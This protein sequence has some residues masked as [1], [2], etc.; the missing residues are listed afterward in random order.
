MNIGIFTDTYYPQINGVVTSTRMLEK[1]LNRL[2]H[3]V[4]IFTTTDPQARNAAPRV[5]RLPSMPLVFLKTHRVALFY[6]PKL[7][8]RVKQFKLDIVHTQSEFPLGIFGKLV[9]EIYR[10]PM[11]HT[12]HTMYEDYV[13]YI[14][15]GHLI[16]PK[17]AQQFSRVFCNRARAVIAPVDKTHQYLKEIGVI[18]PIHIIPTGLDFAPFQP[19]RFTQAELAPLRYELGLKPEDRVVVTVGRVAKEK[20]IDVLVDMMP[21]LLTR[22]P[23]VKLL[24]VG[25]GPMREPLTAQA[26]ALGIADSVIFTGFKPWDDVPKYYRLGD[27]FATA[28]TSETQGLSYIEAMASHVP[29][30]VKK[31][32]SFEMLIRHGE[33]GFLFDRN[34]DAADTVAYVLTHPEAARCAVERGYEAIQPFSSATFA[35]NLE[36]VYKD[37]LK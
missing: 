3:R 22:V 35:K 17:M 1:E 5:F 32:P 26:R 33:T 8:L 13:H 9:S 2:G 31:D 23:H 28:S 4:Y 36:N 30:A 24:I 25:D 11:V 27:V 34:E 29:V 10:I 19:D 21:R 37:L 16:T 15:N 6:P 20:S 12:Y 14:A 18:R 7:I